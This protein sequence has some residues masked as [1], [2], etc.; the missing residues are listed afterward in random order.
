M[1]P[2]P[3]K[4]ILIVDDHP[5]I[6]EGLRTLISREPDLS[7]CGEA[8]TAAEAL[9]ATAELNPDLVL[10]DIGLPGRNGLELIKDLRAFHPA[11]PILVLSMHDELLWAER[12][13]RAGARGYV[14]KRETGPVMVQAIRQVLANQLCVSEKIS[15]RILESFAGHRVESSPLGLLSDREFEVFELIGRGKSTTEIAGDL[16][17]STK[18]VE[19]HRAKIKE[20]LELKTMPELIS[21][22]ARW[23]ETQDTR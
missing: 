9:K 17:L 13:L 2:L 5:M 6:R 21:F 12:V 7:V 18:T 14:M 3:T 19:A 22:A 11:L 15:A 10:V 8:E 1:P 23:V 4:R 20:K 16:H